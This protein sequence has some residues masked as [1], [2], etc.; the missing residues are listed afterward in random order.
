V[1]LKKFP[2]LF[3]FFHLITLPSSTWISSSEIRPFPGEDSTIWWEVRL[4]LIT[5]G[6]YTVNEGQSSFPGSY[7]FA[8]LW[9]GCMERDNG[10]FLLYRE[11]VSLLEWKAQE[12]A[13]LP[14][15]TLVL[16]PNE[17]PEKPS[18]NLNYI[19]K[20]EKTLIIDFNVEGFHVPQ[21]KSEHKFYLHLPISKEHSL[22]FSN[23]DYESFISFGSNHI[24][25]KEKEI[26]SKS[27]K[28]KFSWKWRYQN[29]PIA[30]KKHVYFTNKHEVEVE[31][32][33]TPHSKK[34]SRN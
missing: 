3:L 23:I 34:V 25:L 9:T 11:N 4:L 22:Q 20:K 32:Y 21:Y 29:W 6:T 13:F 15:N 33:L 10:D 14:D 30:Q 18:F 24:S 19:L 2:S 5:K 27:I 16:S 31:I 26:Y 7:S 12:T 8:F 28:K 1:K 17:F